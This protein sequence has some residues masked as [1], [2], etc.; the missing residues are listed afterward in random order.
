MSL[1]LDSFFTNFLH[2]C[3]DELKWDLC[4][5]VKNVSECGEFSNAPGVCIRWYISEHQASSH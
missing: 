1:I 2:A 4:I 3:F 5:D